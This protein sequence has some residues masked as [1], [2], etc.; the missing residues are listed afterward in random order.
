MP[1]TDL[2]MSQGFTKLCF[3]LCFFFFSFLL[4][5]WSWICIL[6]NFIKGIF[7][8]SNNIFLWHESE[9]INKK[10]LFPKF[11]LIPILR[12]QVMHDYVCFIAPTDYCAEWS[13]VFETF[14]ENCSHFKLN[15]F[16]PNSFEEVCFL[17]EIYENMQTFKFWK[18]WECPL[19]DIGGMP[20]NFKF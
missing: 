11:Q 15:W 7:I 20:L 8:D 9:D 10:G 18:F 12:F 4:Q 13:L 2:S 5:T 6:Y 17:E 19:F 14:C 16:Q 1:L 3:F